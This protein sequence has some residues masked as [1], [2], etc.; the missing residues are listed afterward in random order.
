MG[1]YIFGE[2][3]QPAFWLGVSL[4]VL[5]IIITQIASQSS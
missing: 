2:R 5:G 3:I 4:I 1:W